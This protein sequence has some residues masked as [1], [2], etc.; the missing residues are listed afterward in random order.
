MRRWF[1]VEGNRRGVQ[2][3]FQRSSAAC[4]SFAPA[5]AWTQHWAR[6]LRQAQAPGGR[7]QRRGYYRRAV[8]ARRVEVSTRGVLNSATHM[9]FLG[10]H[11]LFIAR[12][13]GEA[14][15]RG[16]VTGG[17][18]VPG[19]G[20]VNTAQSRPQVAVAIYK[21]YTVHHTVMTCRAKHTV[22]NGPWREL[23]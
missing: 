17:S 7:G 23:W 22:I 9:M 11:T 21:G 14:R 5:R 2:V 16:G 20:C 13:R 6:V 4:I 19:V 15:A 8:S 10:A 3:L 12:L 18:A 1:L